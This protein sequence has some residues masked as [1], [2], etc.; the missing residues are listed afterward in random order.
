MLKI[1][2]S[3]FD[4]VDKHDE[5]IYMIDDDQDDSNKKDVSHEI[6]SDVIRKNLISLS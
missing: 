4:L 2:V 5:G 1:L 6:F 3:K